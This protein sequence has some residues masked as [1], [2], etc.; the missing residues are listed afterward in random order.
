[1]RQIYTDGWFVGL[2]GIPVGFRLI[3]ASRLYPFA[4]KKLPTND[5]ELEQLWAYSGGYAWYEMICDN[6]N[7]KFDTTILDEALIGVRPWS[8][9]MFILSIPIELSEG[10]CSPGAFAWLLEKTKDDPEGRK[11]LYKAL[12]INEQKDGE[13]NEGAHKAAG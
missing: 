13:G 9:A 12:N 5:N 2:H 6:S 10:R 1:M 7:T 3:W 8:D 11:R 4:C